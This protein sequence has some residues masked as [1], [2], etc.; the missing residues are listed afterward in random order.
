[1]L[2]TNRTLHPIDPVL[3]NF[4][5]GYMQGETR[6]VAGRAANPISVAEQSGTY[7]VF[8]KKYWFLDE[9]KRRAPGG[10]YAMG[11]YG[12]STGTY[13]T[14]QWALAHAIPDENRAANQT[15]ID[16]ETAGS[17]WLAGRALIRKEQLFAPLMAAS[18][19]GTDKSV[20][21]KWSV[22]TTCAPVS[23]VR[24]AKRFISQKTGFTPNTMICGEIVEDRLV[25]AQ[26]VVDRLK[27]T[28]AATIQSVR[29]ALAALLGIDQIF[30]G[31]AIY[32]SANENATGTYAAI[33][34]DDAL[35]CYQDPNPGLFGATAFKAFY[36]QPGGG[37]G[38]VGR[39]REEGN[40]ADVLKMK[41]QLVF[42]TVASDLGYFFS[43]VTD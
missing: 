39:Y 19:W 28:N 20:S 22:A 25:V 6:F 1:M 16:L 31:Q 32:N 37:L 18:V 24:D 11:G 9:M 17:Q 4:A 14:E 34:D 3:T 36:W 30:V 7:M 8:T 38:T 41:M 27:Y 5:L 40:D 21:V 10:P 35:V 23:D 42:K 2:P 33:L 13:A 26:E 15:G 12:V 29:Q 43:D